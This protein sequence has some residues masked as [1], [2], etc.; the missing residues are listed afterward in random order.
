MSNEP[1]QPSIGAIPEGLEG[2]AKPTLQPAARSD[3]DGDPRKLVRT[4]KEAD[5]NNPHPLYCVWEITLQC[6]LGCKHCGSRAG[7]ARPDELTTQECFDVVH[8]LADMGVREV[9]LIGGEAYLRDDWHLIAK[10]ATRLGLVCGMTTGA[11]NLTQERVDQAVDAGMRTISISLDGLEKTHDALRGAKGAWRS[12]MEAS[13]RISASP[14]RLATN[15]QIN[16][17]SMP[18][19]PALADLL[20]EIGSKAWQIQIT[21][22]MGRAADRPELLLQ[23]YE[24]LEL[25]P[26]LVWIKQTKLEPNGVQLF[27]GN[28]IGYFGPYEHLLR[29]GG[30]RG[31]HWSGCSAGLWTLGL[32][33]D[34]KIKGCPSL[35][36]TSYTGGNI[37][38]AAIAEVVKNSK[39]L[40]YLRERTRE[41]LWGYCKE[42][43]YG[44]ICKGGCSWTSHCL[45]GRPGNNPYCIHRALQFEAQGL[46]ESVIKV[47]AAP[48]DPFDNG[49]FE[50]V[51]EPMP[52]LDETTPTILGRE[53]PD[54]LALATGSG[55]VWVDEKEG[56]KSTLKR[57]RNE[58]PV[59]DDRWEVG[60]QDAP[61]DQDTTS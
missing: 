28:N 44:D 39:E 48:G 18:E 42:C 58:H 32:E 45:L 27:P 37:R 26:L 30:D 34:G 13:E 25:F 2:I 14:I 36:S 6:D 1:G 55:G 51:V 10:E 8:Q 41:D 9:T 16:R 24:L 59:M 20:T 49:R 52:A 35:P 23:P 29:Y 19:M 43:Y 5:L 57:D 61:W 3:F 22:A 53:L 54:L 46:R 47:E 12:A 4:A 40:R 15:T 17:L 7:K 11:R 50:I 21:V 31:A 56:M 33:A 38:D 60:A